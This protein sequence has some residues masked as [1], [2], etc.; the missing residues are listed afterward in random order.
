MVDPG[1]RLIEHKLYRD[2]CLNVDGNF[3]KVCVMLFVVSSCAYAN[4]LESLTGK[5]PR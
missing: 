1:S 3:L 2:S 4:E 5:G